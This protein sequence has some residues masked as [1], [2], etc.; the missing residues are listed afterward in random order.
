MPIHSI[1]NCF[2]LTACR[3]PRGFWRVVIFHVFLRWRSLLIVL[4]VCSWSF[5]ELEH[6]SSWHDGILN[7]PFLKALFTVTMFA[8][9]TSGCTTCTQCVAMI[10]SRLTPAGIL[11]LMY[12]IIY[13]D[14]FGHPCSSVQIA[15]LQYLQSY[16]QHSRLCPYSLHLIAVASVGPCS[17]SGMA[18]I[19][20]LLVL[21]V[22]IKP[23][24]PLLH[25]GLPE[26]EAAN[27]T[28][29]DQTGH[30]ECC[31]ASSLVQKVMVISL[32][33]KRRGGSGQP[34]NHA[35]YAP[36]NLLQPVKDPT[37]EILATTKD[38]PHPVLA[39]TKD[40]LV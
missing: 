7:T 18:L 5:K 13:S 21:H 37:P 27:Q 15:G 35:G 29:T 2:T 17:S 12:S 36:G 8:R 26:G 31:L 14:S 16:S 34:W 25:C 4:W 6:G 33:E 40:C 22:T 23:I 20:T 30:T 3:R 19:T 32:L 24:V 28:A 11:E 9:E 39:T 1:L 38:F 10:V